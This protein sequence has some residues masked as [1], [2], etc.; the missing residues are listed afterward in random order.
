MFV[1]GVDDPWQGAEMTQFPDPVYAQNN[2]LTVIQ[3]DCDT[4]AHCIDLHGDSEDSPAGLISAHKEMDATLKQWFKE[5][6]E[7]RFQ[8]EK[9]FFQW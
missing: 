7:P 6:D 3:A 2:R 4:C 9:S 8:E 5:L 1:Y